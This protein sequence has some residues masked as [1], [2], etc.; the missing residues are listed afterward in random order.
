MQ[1]HTTKATQFDTFCVFFYLAQHPALWYHWNCTTYFAG[2]TWNGGWL[3]PD[4]CLRGKVRLCLH[5]STSSSLPAIS[6]FHCRR[7]QALPQRNLCLPY[8]HRSKRRRYRPPRRSLRQCL[9]LHRR[10]CPPL[11]SHS[12]ECATDVHFS[13][14]SFWMSSY[15]ANLTHYSSPTSLKVLEGVCVGPKMLWTLCFE[16]IPPSQINVEES[17]SRPELAISKSRVESRNQPLTLIL[18]S[19]CVYLGWSDILFVPY[20]GICHTSLTP[21]ILIPAGMITYCKHSVGSVDPFR[22]LTSWMCFSASCVVF[23]CF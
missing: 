17:G 1:L 23:L 19:H 5:T 21:H 16:N 15:T 3:S 4:H 12:V 22:Q 7:R 14:L 8:S 13:G 10:C 9:W 11:V 20:Y 18:V 2:S 6:I